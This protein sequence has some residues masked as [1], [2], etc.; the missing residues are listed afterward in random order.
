MGCELYS[1]S[2]HM[3]NEPTFHCRF[4]TL[5]SMALD[6]MPHDEHGG[7]RIRHLGERA[8]LSEATNGAT[9]IDLEGRLADV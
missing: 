9:C 5:P 3:G 7:T 8:V 1:V 6:R 4:G 2:D